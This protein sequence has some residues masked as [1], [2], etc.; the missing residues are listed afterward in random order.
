[1]ILRSK[2]RGLLITSITLL[3][4]AFWVYPIL[5]IFNPWDILNSLFASFGDILKAVRSKEFFESLELRWYLNSLCISTIVTVLTILLSAP[6]AYAVSRLDFPGK[7]ILFWLLMAGIIIPKEILTVP[8]FIDLAQIRLA[9]TYIGI[10]LP[11]VIAPLIILAFKYYFDQV[12][13][14]LREAAYM[15]GASEWRIL[16]TVYIP[17]NRL[18]T[19]VLIIY[20]FITT[21]NN[22]FWPFIVTYSEKLMTLPV[23]LGTQGFG[24]FG[25]VGLAFMVIFF[26][27]LGFLFQL[28]LIQTGIIQI[29][30]DRQSAKVQLRPLLI[31]LG[32]IAGFAAIAWGSFSI[33]EYRALR[34]PLATPLQT[35]WAASVTPENVHPEYPRP[36]LVREN[37]LNLNGN[38]DYALTSKR[39]QEPKNFTG[40]ILV[41][42]PI[43][44]YLSGVALRA[45]TRKLWYHRTFALP[46]QWQGQRIIL[47]FGAAD[48][49]AKVWVNDREIGT[50]QGGYD[51]FSFDI[52]D[53]FRR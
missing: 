38:W 31:L 39:S 26:L 51:N 24:V 7:N 6:C 37:W 36:Q 40:Q 52:T 33:K 5:Y 50:H 18:I 27:L 9:N 1:M 2:A 19:I 11:Q 23:A 17:V 47:H 4:A 16:W 8:L 13:T 41:P 21:W 43:E 48:W 29:G 34:Q 32:S 12:P 53:A 28:L 25:F 10:G 20:T 49:E 22:F 45:D 46:E 44:S 35:K 14:E 15:D 30:V 42:F 3:I